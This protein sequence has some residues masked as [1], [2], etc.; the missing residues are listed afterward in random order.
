MPIQV[1]SKTPLD[2]LAGTRSTDRAVLDHRRRTPQHRRSRPLALLLKKV[3]ANA[4]T[5]NNRT[6]NHRDHTNSTPTT[7]RIR[8][9]VGAFH[10]PSAA[11]C[12]I[13]LATDRRFAPPLPFHEHGPRSPSQLIQRIAQAANVVHSC[14]LSFSPPHHHHHHRGF[15]SNSSLKNEENGFLCVFGTGWI[16]F[17]DLQYLP[18]NASEHIDVFV[19]L[20]VCFCFVRTHNDAL[21]AISCACAVCMYTVSLGEL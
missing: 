20:L 11:A 2:H 15:H 8:I 14:E 19:R 3:S 21:S 12:R 9:T 16:L 10:A 13:P 17:T 6:I 1:I 18:L 7:T 4:P 5:S